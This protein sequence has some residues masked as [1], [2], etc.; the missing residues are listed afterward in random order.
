MRHSS[1]QGLGGEQYHLAAAPPS[2]VAADTAGTGST[3]A[4]SRDAT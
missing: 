4:D 2:C 1:G 3:I